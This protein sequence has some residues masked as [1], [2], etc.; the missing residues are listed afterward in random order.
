MFTPYLDVMLVCLTTS[1]LGSEYK[2]QIKI[3]SFIELDNLKI[4]TGK[5]W[6]TYRNQPAQ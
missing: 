6:H 4:E 3:L 5:D 2:V 1:V